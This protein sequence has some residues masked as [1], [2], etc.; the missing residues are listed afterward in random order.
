M[1]FA[2]FTITLPKRV[3]PPALVPISRVT[4]ARDV[5]TRW[6]LASRTSTS[7]AGEKAAPAVLLVGCVENA[8]WVAATAPTDND[9][10]PGTPRP[11][12]EIVAVPPATPVASPV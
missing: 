3:P 5:V 11:S 9:A 2:A 6:P 7:T 4:A 12:A 8:S 1:P 10:L